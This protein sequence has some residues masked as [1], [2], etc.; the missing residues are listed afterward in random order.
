MLTR[1]KKVLSFLLKAACWCLQAA[2]AVW[3]GP[4]ILQEMATGQWQRR[5]V[6]VLKVHRIREQVS[7]E[8]YLRK[9]HDARTRRVWETRNEFYGDAGKLPPRRQ[10]WQT[11]LQKENEARAKRLEEKRNKFYKTLQQPNKN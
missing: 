10:T 2:L 8:I 7:H 11:R 4:V 6:F 3:F 9:Q 1:S 5:K